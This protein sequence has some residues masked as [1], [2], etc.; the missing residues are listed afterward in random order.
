MSQAFAFITHVRA[1]PG[2]RADVLKDADF[3]RYHLSR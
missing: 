1:K 3:G 2:K